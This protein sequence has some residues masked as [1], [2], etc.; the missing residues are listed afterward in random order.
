MPRLSLKYPNGRSHDLEYDGPVRFHVGREF[1]LYGRRWRVSQIQ[2]PRHQAG[3]VV[4]C[5]PL[6]GS[7]LTRS[8]RSTTA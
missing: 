5:V 1:E 2:R 6:T 3:R 8:A 4:D 7:P